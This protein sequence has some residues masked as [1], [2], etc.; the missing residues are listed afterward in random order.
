MSDLASTLTEA[1]AH[2]AAG[3]LDA[4]EELSRAVL[5]VDPRS[6]RALH[7]LGVVARRTKRLPLAVAVLDD[8]AKIC[9]TDP[10]IQCELGLALS[11][12]QREEEAVDHY[13]RAIEVHP[14]YSDAYVNLAAG[15]DRLERP[16]EALSWAVRAAKL[17]PGNP[18]V[19]FNLGN[20]RRALG[21][22]EQASAAFETAITLDRS[23]A[24]AHW[25]LAC[26]RLLAG[27]FAR[28]WSEYE[29]RE[30]AGEVVTDDYP[31]PRWQGESLD[32]RTILV[33]AEQGIGDEI[34]FAS[35]LPD[36]I[37]RGGR[38]IVVCEP[39][40]E[41]LFARS[42][43]EAI[44]RGFARRKDRK[45]IVLS[46]N[47]DFQIPIGSLPQF[48]RPS[49]ESFPARGRFLVA[50]AELT[51][52]WRERLSALGRG[53][54]VGISWRAGGLPSERRK[55][56]TGLELWRDI[57]AVPGV[58]FVNLQYGETAADISA[59]ARELGVTIHD[60]P[61]ADPLLDLDT[62]AAKIAALDLVMSVGN[63]T[64]HLAGALGVP[65]WAALPKVPGWRWQIAGN[66]SPWYS[67]VRLFRQ[68]DRGDWRPVFSEIAAAL[69]DFI[70]QQSLFEGAAAV[71]SKDSGQIGI[72]ESLSPATGLKIKPAPPVHSVD[73][74]AILSAATKLAA[75]GDLTAAESHCSRILEHS[76]RHAGALNLLGQIARQ[77]GRHELA[78]RTLSRAAAAAEINPVIQLH[79][80]SA[81]HDAG[82]ALPSIASYRR[83]IALDRGL[84][85]AHFG[86]GKALRA[87]GRSR[88]AISAL[89][90][91]IE[92]KPDHHKALNL[93][94]GCYLEAGRWNDAERAFRAAARLL[95]DYMAAHN[96][97]GLALE[98]QERL[99]EALACYDRAVEIDERCLQAVTNLANVL[100]RLGQSAAA[101]LVRSQTAGLDPVG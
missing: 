2:V 84:T 29:W 68:R 53:L 15:L 90:T 17:M 11:E 96:N 91:T 64:V 54:K 70:R 18:I 10:G 59:V 14:G 1:A 77:T 58:Q 36:L 74:E 73:A 35:C 69:H 63:A 32:S 45:G 71:E 21:D 98:R 41:R 42:F 89:E 19:H 3:R 85:E 52:A 81:Q 61:G 95:P 62:F 30:R 37:T 12:S 78:I 82:Q 66:E 33:H 48:F 25:N 28:G 40:L 56:T 87:A 50:D 76:P 43:P 6:P 16:E 44:V 97:L 67:S 22:L 39:R 75:R 51:T 49:R 72:A 99:A 24:N 101:T 27:D 34:L 31:Q 57:F 86:L 65:V 20:I 9:P 80:A 7:V 92:L 4:A 83:A 46:E 60:Q 23:F 13:H 93:L 26:C 94:G 38:M 88:E 47:I 55:R 5:R 79:L 8:A 100:D